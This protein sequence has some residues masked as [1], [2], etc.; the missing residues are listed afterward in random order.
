M[1]SRT[2]LAA[3]LLVGMN[4]LSGPVAAQQ[5]FADVGKQAPITILIN[6]SPW[7][8]GF[9]KVVQLY[10]QQTG[11]TVTLDITPFNG[12]LEKSRNAVRSGTSPYDVLNLNTAWSV[13]FYDGDFLV[14]LKSIDSAFDLPKEAFRYDDS[15]YW[16]KTKR[17]RTSDQGELYG[18]SPN[19]NVHLMYWRGDILEK[20]GVK[21]A[22]T[23][24]E[25]A[26][27]CE[28]VQSK[29]SVYGYAFRGE[30]GNG[31]WF[32]F[33][34]LMLAYGAQVEK[35]PKNGDFTVMINS[36]EA[37]SALD[38]F[39]AIAKKCGPPNIGAL[40]Q[41]DL[42][43]ALA[44]GKLAGGHAVVAAWPTFDDPKKSAVVGKMQVAVL[45]AA[46]GLKPGVV[47]GDWDLG[48]PKN[49][50]DDKKR[51]ALAF[52]K[53][54][55]TAGAQLAYLESGGIPV[56]SD[57]FT[58]AAAAKP[59]NRWMKAYLD[60]MPH[61]KQVLGY[62]EG[63]AVEAII[64][65]RLNQALIGEMSTGKALNTMAEEIMAAF[66]KSGRKTGMLAKLPE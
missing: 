35:D 58:S 64:G 34:P 28:K 45:P 11:N 27:S 48:I 10:Q 23:W 15:G 17:W 13:E 9:E 42:I 57:T 53:W 24:E 33:M 61:A 46:K 56:R 32:D 37:K 5:P 8:N 65:L 62:A 43:Q 31:I 7:F 44:T 21:P 22:A 39:I 60:S 66:Q 16:S 49:I 55:L 6:S 3:A 63:P 38:I 20:A 12:M 41:G 50:A 14:P 2:G 26:E 36:P 51:G 54:F 59:E 18:I 47:I 40:G 29:P 4:L 52:F 25:L 30:R 1:R 19:G